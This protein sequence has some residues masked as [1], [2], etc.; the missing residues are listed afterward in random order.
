MND[1]LSGEKTDT[2]RTEVTKRLLQQ[3]DGILD[4]WRKFDFS[5]CLDAVELDQVVRNMDRAR[6]QFDSKLFFLVIFGPLKAG[7]STLTNTLAGEYVSPTGFGIETTRRPSLIVAAKESGID[8]YFSND[9]KISQLLLSRR[10]DRSKDPSIQLQIEKVLDSNEN[11]DAKLSEVQRIVSQERA[12]VSYDKVHE[13]FDQ[14][15]DFLRGIRTEA[16]FQGRI[17]RNKPMPLNE[18]N[19]KDA[20]TKDLPDEPLLTVIRCKGGHLLNQGVA[21]VDMPGLDGSRSNWQFDPIH[22]WV[23]SRAEFFLF[24]QSSVAALNNET[25]DFLKVIVEQS[26]KPP[27]WLVQNIFDARHWQ[28]EENRKTEADVQREEGRQ[29]IVKRLSEEPQAALGLNLGLAWDAKIEKKSEWLA[30][31]EFPKVESEL[32]DVLRAKRA[33][34]QE[35]TCLEYLRKKAD[36]AKH[37]LGQMAQGVEENRQRNT[38]VR[39][40]FVTAQR[41]LSAVN[42]R[43]ELWEVAAKGKISKVA[44]ETANNWLANLDIELDSLKKRHDCT[45]TGEEVNRDI[46]ALGNK[47]AAAGKEK[48]FAKS[49][50]LSQYFSFAKESCESVEPRNYHEAMVGVGLKEL[51]SPLEPTAEDIPDSPEAHF[52]DQNP[53]QERVLGCLWKKK[54]DGGP[55]GVHIEILRKEW[56]DEVQEKTKVWKAKFLNEHFVG[57]CEKRRK[58][59]RLHLEEQLANF[60]AKTKPNEEAANA[61]EKLIQEMNLAL[62]QLQLPLANAIASMK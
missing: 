22:K 49:F 59:Y 39:V 5:R 43:T 47:L 48:H 35:Q 27:F 12:D 16:E 28:L 14:I 21:I 51:L 31:S 58:Q 61:T 34:I 50:V 10:K 41:L 46:T 15:A 32:T 60:E 6:R 33:L 37:Q 55:I 40:A 29:L 13:A 4:Q 11:G 54:H 62:G 57:Y 1:S 19:L 9:G 53:L 23:V 56:R 26:T 3:I 17:R 38:Q 18:R 45:R 52:Q 30:R 2:A 42:Y 25:L 36:E 20:L 24:V 7:K 8:Q 44:D